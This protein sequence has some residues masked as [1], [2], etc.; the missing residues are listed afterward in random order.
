MSTVISKTR[1]KN[2][3]RSGLTLDEYRKR[4]R[5]K[6]AM[7]RELKR[8]KHLQKRAGRGAKKSGALKSPKKEVRNG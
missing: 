1:Q 3:D 5:K 2:L 6:K 4:L 7:D 8:R